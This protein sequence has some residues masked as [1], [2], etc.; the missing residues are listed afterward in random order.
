MTLSLGVGI[1]KDLCLPSGLAMYTL[2]VPEDLKA[3]L[4][5]FFKGKEQTE[6]TEQTLILLCKT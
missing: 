5:G 3:T 6:Q 2:S 4:R 1:P